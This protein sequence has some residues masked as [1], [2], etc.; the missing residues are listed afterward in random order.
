MLDFGITTAD[1]IYHDNDIRDPD[2]FMTHVLIE[3][4]LDFGIN[5]AYHIGH[6]NDVRDSDGYYDLG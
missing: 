4:L 5:L 6:D 1:H 2:G 3:I